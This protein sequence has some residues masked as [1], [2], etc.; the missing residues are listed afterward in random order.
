ME[1]DMNSFKH[2]VK[3]SIVNI[4]KFIKEIFILASVTTISFIAFSVV[5]AWLVGNLTIDQAINVKLNTL[6]VFAYF[7]IPLMALAICTKVLDV[8]IL[9]IARGAKTTTV[10]EK[11]E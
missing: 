7:F 4:L 1:N 6:L 3:T 2:S 10:I 11:S 9:S 8:I 5:S